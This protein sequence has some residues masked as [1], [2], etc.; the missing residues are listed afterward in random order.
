MYSQNKYCSNLNNNTRH[1]KSPFKKG[2]F[3]KERDSNLRMYFYTTRFPSVREVFSIDSYKVPLSIFIH[4]RDS[5][6]EH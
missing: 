5:K 3:G 1:L 2:L 4:I 6:Y